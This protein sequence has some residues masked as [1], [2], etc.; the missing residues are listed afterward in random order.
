MKFT[1]ELVNE[2]SGLLDQLDEVAKRPGIMSLAGM[3]AEKACKADVASYFRI[4]GARVKQ[5]HLEKLID[6]ND[7]QQARHAAEMK[8]RQIA[9]RASDVLQRILKEHIHAAVVA[10][11]KQHVYHE[12]SGDDI[13]VGPASGQLSADAAAYAAEQA[14]QQVVGINQTTVDTLSDLVATAVVNQMTHIHAALL[15]ADKQQV[16]HEASGDDSEIG[17]ASGLLSSDAEEYAAEQAAKQIVGINQTTVDKIA[18]LVATAVGNQMTPSDLSR[19][20]RDLLDGWT[21]DRAEMVARTEMADA[22][23]A[24]AL[25]KFDREGID[26]M[27]LILSPDACPICESIAANGPVRVDDGF[28]DDDGETYDRSPIHVNCRCATVGARAPEGE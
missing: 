14:A 28:E 5:A 25:M 19:D 26:Y 18:D 24:A 3:Q 27:Q 7:K 11:D 13:E 10:A 4:L 2:L 6:V 8:V 16:Y 21:T 22:F 20:L 9:R 1:S 17:P 23:G 15:A 12:A